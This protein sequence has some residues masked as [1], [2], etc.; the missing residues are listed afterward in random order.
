MRTGQRSIRPEGPA[1][2]LLLA[3]AALLLLAPAPPAWAVTD[4]NPCTLP[5]VDCTAPPTARVSGPN[6]VPVFGPDF[7]TRLDFVAAGVPNVVVENGGSLQVQDKN[8]VELGGCPG[9]PSPGMWIKAARVTVRNGGSIDGDTFIIADRLTNGGAIFLDLTGDLIVE[10]GGKI[11]SDRLGTRGVGRGGNITAVVGGRIHVQADPSGAPRGVIRA[12]SQASSRR[13]FAEG[14]GL[15]EVT[16]VATG[17]GA[18]GAEAIRID[19][20]V[21]I[22][23]P[24]PS[25]EAFL[26]G[27][28][29]LVGGGDTAPGAT[30]QNLPPFPSPGT[31]TPPNPPDNVAKVVVG[32]TGVVNTEAKDAGGGIIRI[33]AC[34]FVLE[35]PEGLIQ[36]GGNATTGTILGREGRLPVIILI[37]VNETITVQAG[38]QILADLRQGFKQHVGQGPLC[39]FTP[40][41]PPDANGPVPGV[42]GGA[43]ICLIARADISLEGSGGVFAVSARTLDGT[44]TGGS[45]V[46]LSTQEGVVELI[47]SAVTVD[48]PASGGQGGMVQIQAAQDVDV[49]DSPAS[50]GV[51]ANDTTGVGGSIEV[52]AVSGAITRST[53]LL[54][55]TGGGGAGVITLRECGVNAADNPA[56]TPAATL[57]AASCGTPVLIPASLIPNLRPCVGACFCIARLRQRTSTLTI[58]GEGLK[59]VT[60][61][62]VNAPGCDPNTGTGVAFTVNDAGTQITVSPAPQLT[63]GLFTILSNPGPDAV[64]GT[65]DDAAS[66]CKVQP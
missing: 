45:V 28:I 56:S 19:G 42:R 22:V 46:V 11:S 47:G 39:A 35:G 5:F 48:S 50:G 38:A 36:A 9:T 32:G 49:H 66:S 55:A 1:V 29:T 52:E 25:V 13:A 27:I 21:E 6:L 10:P 40:V 16:L 18:P 14:C 58:V 30:V 37:Q 3:V 57:L 65:A 2:G 60:R 12:N 59:G 24:P 23:A 51:R 4:L 54:L 43:D 64:F 15:T 26:G 63:P 7:I 34:F 61:V 33:F 41:S 8:I 31:I 20:T 53:G 17:D 62:E 44:Q